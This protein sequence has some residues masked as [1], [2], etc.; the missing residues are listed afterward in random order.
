MV[1]TCTGLLNV[2]V[3]VVVTDIPVAPEAGVKLVSAGGVVSVV[4]VLYETSTQ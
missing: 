3:T 2:A 1:L 4:L